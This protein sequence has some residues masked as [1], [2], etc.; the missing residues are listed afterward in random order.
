[1]SD[2]K[3]RFGDNNLQDMERCRRVVIININFP[4]TQIRIREHSNGAKLGPI[5][6]AKN[7]KVTLAWSLFDLIHSFNKNPKITHEKKNINHE[8]SHAYS[9]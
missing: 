8:A 1:M 7:T 4:P 5:F 9:H 2:A 3:S 6:W